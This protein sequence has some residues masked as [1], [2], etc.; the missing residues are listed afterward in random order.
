MKE[1]KIY[2]ILIAMLLVFFVIMFLIFGLNASKDDEYDTILIVSDDTV[3]AYESDKWSNLTSFKELDGEKYNVYLNNEKKGNYYLS[4]NDKWYASDDK[5]KSIKL[6]GDL[7]AIKS[8]KNIS[9]YN[10]STKNIDDYS[11]V[12]SVLKDNNLPTD[13]QYTVN[14]K[15]VFDYDDDGYDEEFFLISNAFPLD[16]SPSSIFSIVFMVKNGEIYTIYSGIENNKGYNGCMPYIS[17]FIDVNNDS[18]YEV[19]LSCAKYSVSGVNRMLYEYKN[20]EFKMLISN[21][22]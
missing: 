19:I 21:N 16:F 4:Y 22:K 5:N 1:N 18:K 3:W 2:I 14:K 10:F 9:V 12:Y 15:I 20:N 8:S 13:S 7:L 11:Y 6:E 17:S